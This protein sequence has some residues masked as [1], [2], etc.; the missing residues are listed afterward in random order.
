MC[1]ICGIVNNHKDNSPP[2]VP[3]LLQMMGSLTHRGPDS[4]GYYRDN[5]AALAHTR[6]AII[7]V[8]DGAQPLSNED[9][10]IWIT[11]NGEIFNYI[12]LA[13]ILKKSG[14]K[15]RTKSDTEVIVHAYEEWGV[16]CFNKF[17]G[18]WALALWDKRKNTLILS[19]DRHGIRPLYYTFHNKRFYFASE[20]KAI[21]S[22]TTVKREFDPSGLHQVFT[23]WSPV[24]P[25]TVFKGIF[26]LKPG[27]FGCLKNG[28]LEEEASFTLRFPEKK[29]INRKSLEENAEEL[30]HHL[31]TASKLRF[32]R[33]D[34]PVGAYLSGGLDSSISSA[35]VSRF[36]D[37]PLK[38][39]SIRFTDPE[40]DE[41][42]YQNEMVRYLGT[43][44]RDVAVSQGDIGSIFPEV[45]RHTERPIL[46]TAP[47]PLFLL[48]KLV[49]ESGYKVVVTGEGADEVLAGYDIFREEKV[50]RFLARGPLSEKRDEIILSLYPW[51]ARSPGKIPAF[52]KAFFTKAMDPSDPGFSHR[53]RWNTTS[54][55][56]LMVSPD[57]R[58]EMTNT[59]V[60]RE[61]LDSLPPEHTAWDSLFRSQYLEMVTLLSGYIL[62][63]Q[64]DRMLMANSVE[65]R[66]PF[67]DCNLVE[68]ANQ[69]PAHHKL[70]ALDEKHILKKACKDLVPS[71]VLTRSKQPYRA[72]DAAS[73]FFAKTPE[74]VDHL[75]D[76]EAV[77]K[78]GIF[79]SQAVS[80]LVY[81]CKKAKGHSMSNTDNMRITA[82]LST[83]LTHHYFIESNPPQQSP[84]RPQTVID[85]AG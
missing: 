76:E 65:G 7:D 80:K 70:L 72:P 45:I 50:R 71:S 10:T 18:Q 85:L 22:D 56:L 19:R 57:F 16:S 32:T 48:S 40:F 2:E 59:D 8:S 62:S 42:T 47:A 37:T 31:L 12:E 78:A 4:S 20:M 43:E 3:L 23:F 46:R 79:N 58:E 41:G 82:I 84:P 25:R 44:H 26:E 74:W 69:L 53:P 67:L 29:E 77:K 55:L 81:K 36:T 11:F 1:G 75:T 21:F 66:F 33:S 28:R 54:S 60:T 63:A 35:I 83:M 68:F 34:V 73:F 27:H 64:G 51:M 6:L 9:K 17:N 39:F 15:F 5:L 24:A 30:R 61:L 14:H 49:R 52:A 13:E 38:T